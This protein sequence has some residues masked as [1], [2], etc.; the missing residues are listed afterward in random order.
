MIEKS[1]EEWERSSPKEIRE[2][3]LRCKQDPKHFIKT[4]VHII[5][6]L[7]GEVKFDLFPFQ[8][9][10][11]DNLQEHRF[12]IIRKFRQAGITTI[13]CAYAL[14]IIIFQKN[15]T[16]PIL[17]IGDKE[18]TEVKERIDLMFDQLP[19]FLKPNIKK[20]NEH[21]LHLATGSKVV[22]RPSGKASGRSLSGYLLIIDEA[23]FIEKIDD[24]WA[25]VYPTLATGGR[26]LVISTVNGMGN[27]YYEQYTAGRENANFF[28]AVD[29]YWQEH[30]Q[31]YYNENYQN[32]Y[33]KLD[34]ACD[35][36]G[37]ERLNIQS[38]EEVTR[39]NLG[40]RR[41][42]QEFLAEF[43][44]TGDTYIDGETLSVLYEN[45]DEGFGIKYNNRMR[46]WE[47][48]N[49]YHLYVMGVDTSLGRELDYSAFHIIDAYNGK[50]V[51]EFY[52]NKT[53]IDEFSKIISKE[54]HYYNIALVV[55][56]R[57]TIGNY[58]LDK[59]FKEEEYENLW[60]DDRG[61]LGYQMG[62]KVGRDNLLAAM[63]ESVRMKKIELHSKRT[64]EELMTFVIKENGKAE[65]DEGKNDDLVISLAL[66]VFALED[67]VMN[68]P[69]LMTKLTQEDTPLAPATQKG[70][71]VS[72]EH[73]VESY[74][75]MTSE[76]IK[77]LLD[78]N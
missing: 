24:I 78:K 20:N 22:S 12:N 67:L 59:L 25:G 61:I 55:A 7:L 50:Q 53:P 36:L 37:I 33:D 74:G 8:E 18:S 3:F 29:I 39:K 70:P 28:N 4:H 30:P 57:N 16:I 10:I 71:N 51:A 49:P 52:S 41:W 40:L 64:V 35:K 44:G 38:F 32:L 76:D 2:E 75:G 5:H 14:W 27:W 43:L 48:P 21:I 69:E 46:V 54:G 31:Y 13:A 15:K 9:R 19:S 45:V 58:L 34:E 42:R 56:E 1:I 73:N 6:Q 72:W 63:E 62:S 68:A 66:S 17:S 60:A 47:E 65:A 11:I 77:W 26:A 23:A